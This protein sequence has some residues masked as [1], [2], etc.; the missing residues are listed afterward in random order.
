MCVYE[1][2][3]ETLCKHHIVFLCMLVLYASY[4]IIMCMYCVVID[5]IILQMCVHCVYNVLFYITVLV[6]ISRNVNFA[7]LRITCKPCPR[8]DYNSLTS[9]IF[10]S[11]Y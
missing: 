9:D 3:S 10:R 5:C 1:F 7:V 6:Q 4:D 8:D 11:F 2:Y